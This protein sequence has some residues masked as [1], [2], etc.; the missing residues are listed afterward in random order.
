MCQ[1]VSALGSEGSGNSLK[2]DPSKNNIQT[3]IYSRVVFWPQT[4]DHCYP[5]SVCFNK[6][7]CITLMSQ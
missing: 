6:D 3:S 7:G 5:C 1:G 4:A 2:D